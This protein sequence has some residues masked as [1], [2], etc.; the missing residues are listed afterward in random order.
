LNPWE[1]IER[2]VVPGTTTEMALFKRGHELAIRV[3]G[4]ELM[5][6]RMHGSEDALADLAY[7]VLDQR[8]AA[9]IAAGRA[10]SRRVLVGG[11]G[12]G[13]TLAAALKRA[14][15]AGVVMVAELVPAVVR[16]NQGVLGEAAGNPLHDPRAQVHAG[17]VAQ[18]IKR[19]PAPW[20][21]ILLDVD[22]GPDGLTRGSNEWLYTPAGLNACHAALTPGGVLGVWSAAPDEAFTRRMERAGF[23]TKPVRVRARGSKGRANI[24]WVGVRRTKPH[25]PRRR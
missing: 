14:Q 24:V 1:L 6:N 23:D 9:A 20:D 8:D 4:L 13:F 12:V 19:P 16:W 18:L 3:D 5:G 7:D 17:D 22:N 25:R 2:T 15:P 11:L 21:A 10:I